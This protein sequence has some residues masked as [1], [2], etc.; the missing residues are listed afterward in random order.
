MSTKVLISIENVYK[1]R[2][3]SLQECKHDLKAELPILFQAFERAKD[4]YNTEIVL[5]PPIARCRGHEAMLLNSKMIQAIQE[6]FPDKWR[7][8]KY[9]RFTLRIRG[10]QILFKKLDS[11]NRPMN[12]PTGLSMAINNQHSLS[13]FNDNTFKYEPL[14][15]FGYRKDKLGRLSDPKIVYIDEGRMKWTIDAY[16]VS[17]Q[18]VQSSSLKSVSPAIAKVK[19]VKHASETKTTG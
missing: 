1:R 19:A 16:D 17:T 9:K 5:T 6:F 10:Y 8:G 12:I 18:F 4:L 15:F 2:L 14:L 13:L 7:F 11:K 3:V